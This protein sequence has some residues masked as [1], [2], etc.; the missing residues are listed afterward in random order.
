MD[1]AAALIH[2]VNENVSFDGVRDFD[3]EQNSRLRAILD[4]LAIR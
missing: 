1:W 4:A 3:P 2:L